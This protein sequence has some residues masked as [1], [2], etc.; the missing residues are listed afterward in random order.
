MIPLA[1]RSSSVHQLSIHQPRASQVGVVLHTEQIARQAAEAIRR[2][3]DDEILERNGVV[4]PSLHLPSDI[5][6]YVVVINPR[7]F[8][9]RF[10]R[11]P[12]PDIEDLPVRGVPVEALSLMR[13][14]Q[15]PDQPAQ[16]VIAIGVIGAVILGVGGLVFALTRQK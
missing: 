15:F 4:R 16:Q 10:R 3:E 8:K 2:A 1:F 14:S 11:R 13:A 12:F 9:R 5:A 6:K 7:G